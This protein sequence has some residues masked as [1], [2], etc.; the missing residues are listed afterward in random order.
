MDFPWKLWKWSNLLFRPP[1]E[2]IFIKGNIQTK[3]LELFASKGCV[4]VLISTH[5]GLLCDR[6]DAFLFVLYLNSVREFGVLVPQGKNQWFSVSEDASLTVG[7]SQRCHKTQSFIFY[8]SF[9]T[10]RKWLEAGAAFG[11]CDSQRGP[12]LFISKMGE[13]QISCLICS[14]SPTLFYYILAHT[15]MFG[16]AALA[17]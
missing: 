4:L 15:E 16:R 3:L 2:G 14:P 9:H 6:T 12:V 11:K 10:S 1:R 17:R 5:A 13:C 7:S 8:T